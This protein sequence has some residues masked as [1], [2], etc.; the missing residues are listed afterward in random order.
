MG[1][2]STYRTSWLARILDL[3]AKPL[4]FWVVLFIADA[5]HIYLF[6][7]YK[8]QQGKMLMTIEMMSASLYVES[9]EKGRVVERQASVK[10]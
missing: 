1:S 4:C 6:P 3:D 9:L 2:C 8:I 7:P 10:L 5:I